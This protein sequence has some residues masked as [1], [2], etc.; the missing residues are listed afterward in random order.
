MSFLGLQVLSSV[1]PSDRGELHPPA[2]AT[3]LQ[4]SWG[5]E[6]AEAPQEGPVS[7][8]M[9]RGCSNGLSALGL[10]AAGHRRGRGRAARRAWGWVWKGG[11]LGGGGG[12]MA[13]PPGCQLWDLSGFGEGAAGGSEMQPGGG[14]GRTPHPSPSLEI[15]PGGSRVSGGCCGP[16]TCSVYLCVKRYVTTH[17][18]FVLGFM[19]R[20]V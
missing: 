4:S 3:S 10:P 1:V 2:R 8:G 20:L 7:P 17:W 14:A 18:F 9:G 16:A 15:G 5:P 13:G 12:D 19:F 11:E 6:E